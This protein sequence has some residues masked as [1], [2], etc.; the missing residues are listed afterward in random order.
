MGWGQLGRGN[1][2]VEEAIPFVRPVD[3]PKP[4]KRLSGLAP[5]A[6]P[7]TSNVSQAS[8]KLEA[9]TLRSILLC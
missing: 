9:I 6:G 8:C 4:G 2:F 5:S 3:I 1:R 7:K